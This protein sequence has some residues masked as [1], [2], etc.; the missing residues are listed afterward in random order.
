LQNIS[1]ANPAVTLSDFFSIGGALN[2]FKYSNPAVDAAFADIATTTDTAKLK[3]AYGIVE[4]AFLKDNPVYLAAQISFA[5][6]SA[7][8]IVGVTPINEGVYPLWGT[9]GLSPTS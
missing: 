1:F 4:A 3:A 6:V 9:I 5:V 7:R 2:T 8:K